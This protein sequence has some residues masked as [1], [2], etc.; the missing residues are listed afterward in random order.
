[1]QQVMQ[2]AESRHEQCARLQ[3]KLD[4]R[5]MEASMK[6]HEVI[7]L[8]QQLEDAEDRVRRAEESAA[9]IR[10]V[11]TFHAVARLLTRFSIACA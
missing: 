8:R 6:Q 2:Q 11:S 7:R 4:Q 3:Q 5:S 9:A 10:W 1:M